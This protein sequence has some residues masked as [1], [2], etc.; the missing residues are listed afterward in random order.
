MRLSIRD[1]NSNQRVKPRIM[2]YI[3]DEDGKEI[4]EIKEGHVFKRI[5]LQDFLDQITEC[6]KKIVSMPPSNGTV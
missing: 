4:L 1:R 3:C 5:V 2:D 6:R